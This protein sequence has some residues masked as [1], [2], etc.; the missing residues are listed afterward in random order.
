MREVKKPDV[1][2]SEIVDTALRLFARKGYEKTTVEAIIGELGVA[3]GCFYHHFRSKEELFDAC[4]TAA[5]QALTGQYVAILADTSLAAGAR[6][7]RFLD[8]TYRLAE[9][10][11]GILRQ[12]Q[13]PAVIEVDQKV[14]T[15][16]STDLLPAMTD[17]VG[18]GMRSGE[19]DAVD[20]EM[21]ATAVLGALTNLHNVY[22]GRVDLDLAAHRRGVIALLVRILGASPGLGDGR[23]A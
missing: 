5:A 21:T 22:T 10:P 6:L 20:A 2:R 9:A 1:R 15:L 11:D 3:K 17:L 23:D 4:A 18:D 7:V 14:S 12:P 19:F 13:P 8:H 16:V